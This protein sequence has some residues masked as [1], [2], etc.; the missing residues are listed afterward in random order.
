MKIANDPRVPTTIGRSP[1][2]VAEKSLLRN[3]RASWLATW[4]APPSWTRATRSKADAAS[5]NAATS[6]GRACHCSWMARSTQSTDGAR[7]ASDVAKGTK[8]PTIHSSGHRNEAASVA[9]TM[10]PSTTAAA[11][12]ST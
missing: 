1:G 3:F 11:S 9:S 4:R 10:P 6:I 12:G 5:A 7:D 2:S 8:Q